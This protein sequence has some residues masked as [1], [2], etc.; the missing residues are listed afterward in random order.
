[1]RRRTI[2]DGSGRP[3]EERKAVADTIHH[4]TYE[5]QPEEDEE[6][7]GRSFVMVIIASLSG[8]GLEIEDMPFRWLATEPHRIVLA[9]RTYDEHSSSRYIP[10]DDL[11]YSRSL[12]RVQSLVLHLFNVSKAFRCFFL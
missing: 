5:V 10:L 7:M 12:R 1:M 8:R 2:M 11:Q 6:L 4:S 9:R 3:E